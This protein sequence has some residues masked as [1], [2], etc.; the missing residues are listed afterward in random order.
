MN[1]ISIPL[2][3]GQI[4][5][6]FSAVDDQKKPVHLEELTRNSHLLLTFIHGTWCPHCVQTIYRLRRAAS[7][8]A[9]EG[10]GIAIV[11]VDDPNTLRIFRQSAVPAIPF[12]LLADKDQLIHKAY[13]LD[14]LSAYIA[15]DKSRIIR[16]LFLDADHHSYPGHSAIVQALR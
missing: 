6:D 7:T 8:F 12:P 13:H 14:Q 10:I 16:G 9:Q 2:Q 1:S 3:I 5:P 11:A 4:A 15:L